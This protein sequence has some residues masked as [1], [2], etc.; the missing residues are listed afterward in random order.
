MAHPTPETDPQ[1]QYLDPAFGGCDH[2][3]DSRTC[4][5]CAAEAETGT[6]ARI[7]WET[8]ENDSGS[9]AVYL[10]FVGTYDEAAFR[11]YEPD[12]HDPEWILAPVLPGSGHRHYG[13]SPDG[14]KAE[15]ERLLSE[16]VASLGAVWPESEYRFDDDYEPVEVTWAAGRRV[17]FAHPDAGY[18]GEGAE[19][20]KLI[21]PGE[22]YTIGWADIGQSR[23][24]LNLFRAQE[25]LGRFNSV[26]FE[27]VPDE[28]VTADLAAREGE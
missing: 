19:A 4:E 21:T 12:A 26:L 5:D 24:D 2:L 6:A 23:T 8:Y 16:F 28:P 18:P 25:P 3:R 22:V 13:D 10:G 20:A 11:L 7:R 17:R 9:H 27:P 15:A 14:L 1:E